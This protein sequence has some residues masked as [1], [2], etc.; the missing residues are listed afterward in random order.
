MRAASILHNKFFW[1]GV[2]YF[3]SGFPLGVFYEIL[4][5]HFRTQG[6]DLS[7]IGFLSLLGLAWSIK[8]LWAP[9]VDYFRRH[10]RWMFA[11]DLAMAGVMLAFA[12]YAEMAPWVWVAVGL[13]TLLSATNDIA[14][15]GYTIEQLNKRELGIANGLRIGFYRVGLLATGALLMLQGVLGWPGVYAGTALILVCCGVACL[16]ALPERERRDNGLTSAQEELRALAAR[17]LALGTVLAFIA[18]LLAGALEHAYLALA[19]IVLGVLLGGLERRRANRAGE[20]APMGPLLGAFLEMLERPYILPV[21]AFILTFK[22][23]DTTMGF[24]V[25]PFWVDA[26]FTPGE[27]GRAHV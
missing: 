13:F 27:I 2:L 21:L 18:G 4:P 11:V 19:L 17:P 14:I 26:G 1:V 5:V 22:L 9:A 25:K 3:A 24:M 15:D 16:F 12:F 10:R 23:A 8:F 7:D 20:K 6:V